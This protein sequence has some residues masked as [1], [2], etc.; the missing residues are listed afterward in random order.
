MAAP[1]VTASLNAA[2]YA[3]G[4]QMTLTVSYAD[5]DTRALTVTVVVTDA[6][7][8]SSA[9]VRATAVIDPLAITVSDD[10]GRTWTKLSDTGSVAVYRAVA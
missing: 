7:G 2:T 4:D 3:P 8:N 6:Q 10:A 1:T 5:P 9:P